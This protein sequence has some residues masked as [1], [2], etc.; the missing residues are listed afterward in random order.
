[1]G[2]GANCIYPLIGVHEYGWRFTGSGNQQPGV[3]QCA[4]DYQF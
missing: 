2:V 1:M 4:G 3:K